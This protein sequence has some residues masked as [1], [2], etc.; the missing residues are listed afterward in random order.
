MFEQTNTSNNNQSLKIN[1]KK[2][3]IKIIDIIL[4]ELCVKE[5]NHDGRKFLKRLRENLKHE[6]DMLSKSTRETQEAH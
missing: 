3:Q 5:L 2:E 4:E 6:M 1:A